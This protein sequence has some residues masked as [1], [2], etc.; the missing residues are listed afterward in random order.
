[1]TMIGAMA[2]DGFRGFMT[3]DAA[4]SSDVFDRFVE[5]EL[6]PTLKPGDMV[7][8][9]N[10]SAHRSPGARQLIEQTGATILFLPPYSPELNPIEKLWSK[11]KDILRHLKTNSRELFD[12]AVAQAMNAISLDNLRA[13]TKFA[14]YRLA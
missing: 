1:M 12:A 4:T 2:L 11:L 14:G 9:D 6:A 3:I 8:M 7:V 13:W 10:L 5:V